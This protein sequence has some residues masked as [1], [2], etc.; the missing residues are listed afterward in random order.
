[1][2]TVPATPI[3]M[4]TS[5]ISSGLIVV[6]LKLKETRKEYKVIEFTPKTLSMSSKRESSPFTFPYPVASL[7]TLGF[8]PQNI[9]NPELLTSKEDEIGS[10]CPLLL[11]W[12]P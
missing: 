2:G 10:P 8:R 6:L 9:L 7:I 1:M 11:N 4:I 5:N 12:F 3:M